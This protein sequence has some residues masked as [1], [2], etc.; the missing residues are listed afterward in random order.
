MFRIINSIVKT[1]VLKHITAVYMT[2]SAGAIFLL[3]YKFYFR[4]NYF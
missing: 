3:T 4:K 1:I 2:L